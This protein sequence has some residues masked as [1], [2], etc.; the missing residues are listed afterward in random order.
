MSSRFDTILEWMLYSLVSLI[1][2]TIA[3]TNIISGLIFLVW[4]TR[5][6]V[7][8]DISF[9][10]EKFSKLL[11]LLASYILLS[12]IWAYKPISVFDEFIGHVLPFLVIFF[13]IITVIKNERQIRNITLIFLISNL[14]N[15]LVSL[16]L[17]TMT[18]RVQGFTHSPNRLADLLIMFIILCFSI[19]LFEKNTKWKLVGLIGLVPGLGG[20]IV[21]YSR[22]GWISLLGGLFAIALLRS[23]K[24][25]I[26][27]IIIG[28]TIPL[29]VPELVQNRIKSVTDLEHSSNKARILIWKA[30]INMVQ[31]HPILGAGFFNVKHIYER[32]K[33]HSSDTV[34][35][36]LHNIYLNVLA[37][38]GIIGFLIFLSLIAYMGKITFGLLKKQ[39]TSIII[40]FIGISI[41]MLLHGLVDFTIRSI[42]VG[43][44]FTYFTAIIYTIYRHSLFLNKQEVL[45]R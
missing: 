29:F 3:G 9:A 20:I 35:V 11:L 24:V 16:Y 26:L 12:S 5:L 34:Y 43:I 18:C 36:Q 30:G 40:A 2:F 22:G 44:S 37:E 19:V 17:S 8:R 6:I 1:P 21:T 39:K 4:I 10:K 13:V 45:S 42:Q 28:L 31:D 23:K 27:L 7:T 41:A 38:L 25:L 15:S 33:L 32:Y 14:V